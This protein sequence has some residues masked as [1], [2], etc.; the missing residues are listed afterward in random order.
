MIKTLIKSLFIVLLLPASLF[1]FA[2]EAFDVIDFTILHTSDI[3]AH[4]MPFDG[5]T[6]S[7]VGGYAR[8]KKYKESL[9]E[10]GREVIMLSSGDIFQGTFFYRFFQ[11][12][13][14]IEYMNQTGYSAM[15]LGNHEFD[16]GQE[17]LTEAISRANFPILA[18]NINFKKI[19]Q[20]QSK[21]KPYTFINVSRHGVAAKIA[22]IGLVPE[23][24]KEIVQPIFVKD[25]DVRSGFDT[26]RRYLPE[27][28]MAKPDMILVL[29]HMGWEKELALFEMFP[30]ID[31]VLG[32]HTHLSID[33]PAVVEGE[34]GHRFISQPGEWGQAVTRY[35][36]SFHHHARQKVEV[37]AAG[38]IKMG[39]ELPQDTEMA[40]K[41]NQLW[42]QIQEK[43]NVPI[44]STETFLNGER[45]Y[46]RR[47]ETNL[48]NLV[49]DCFAEMMPS[50][51]ALINGGGIRSSIATGAITVGDCLNALPFDNYLVQVTL[52]G[53]SLRRIFGQVAQT[54]GEPGGFGGFLQVSRG[55]E[56]DYSQGE[57]Q[58]K[59]NGKEVKGNNLYTVTTNEF[60]AAGGNGLTAF[61]EAV[62]FNSSGLMT[63][64]AFMKFIR[65]K[66]TV[67]PQ[68]ENRIKT[69]QS[70][71]KVKMPKGMVKCI[72][73]PVK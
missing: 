50:D 12:I 20:L 44:G 11:G 72:P 66:V 19:P 65:E 24:L 49:A 70:V 46:I 63:A 30:E 22:V 32:G 55:L 37:V 10:E 53:D 1:G 23:E 3:H 45:T 36:I 15:T 39:N 6:G 57:I 51:M 31:G 4:L 42:L 35:D 28:K 33:P 2:P 62:D 17:A 41:T 73:N 27:I 60:L 64:D 26:L 29:A 54:L 58:L 69:R 7:G 43:V 40:D 8:I 9:E 21:I 16:N 59:F 52:T 38:L 13:P 47:V 68:L 67:N 48:G 14:D 61:T 34:R 71:H 18:A 5:D 25:F 56:V